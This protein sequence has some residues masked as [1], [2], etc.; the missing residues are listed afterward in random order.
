MGETIQLYQFVSNPFWMEIRNKK[1]P[2]VKFVL[3]GVR[4]SMR[5]NA[6]F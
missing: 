2:K 4:S 5:E 3:N 6:R 1:T